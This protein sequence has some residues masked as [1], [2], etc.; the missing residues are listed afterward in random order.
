MLDVYT[1]LCGKERNICGV[2]DTEK[3]RKILFKH[4]DIGECYKWILSKEPNN[5]GIQRQLE[6]YLR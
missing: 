6:F 1:N 2:F 4:K 3:P 5:K